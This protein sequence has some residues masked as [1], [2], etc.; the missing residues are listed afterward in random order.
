MSVAAVT[1]VNKAP[2]NNETQRPSR[3]STSAST[4]PS[5][6]SDNVSPSSGKRNQPEDG[7]NEVRRRRKAEI[8]GG[9]SKST[10]LRTVPRGPAR[11]ALFVTRMN[12][13][14]TTEDIEQFVA[15]VVKD[16]TLVSRKSRALSAVLEPGSSAW[17]CTLERPTC[18][19]RGLSEISER[20]E[21]ISLQP[22]PSFILSREEDDR[23][24][25][26]PSSI[27]GLL[28]LLR[29]P[30]AGVSTTACSQL[31]ETDRRGCKPCRARHRVGTLRDSDAKNGASAPP[32]NGTALWLTSEAHLREE[33]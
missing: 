21:G 33:D 16:D 1:A 15:D 28:P 26:V 25:F 24:R 13:D 30:A 31:G 14:T 12:P 3:Q 6:H 11:K 7:W 9:A 29:M 17:A 23:W 8:R 32:L 19:P 5:T 4:A 22:W 18:A 2:A 20:F 27:S 10:T